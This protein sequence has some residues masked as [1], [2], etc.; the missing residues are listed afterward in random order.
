MPDHIDT[1]ERV[2]RDVQKLVIALTQLAPQFLDGWIRWTEVAR[3]LNGTEEFTVQWSG[4]ASYP[5]WKRL[6]AVHPANLP[7]RVK[8]TD[9]GRD[10]ASQIQLSAPS[11]I[12]RICDSILS[13]AR[14]LDPIRLTVHQVS[15]V[16]TTG[17]RV[18]QAVH[19]DLSDEP[20]PTD[21]P[22]RLLSITATPVDGKIVG[23]E[24]DGSVLYVAFES[25]VLP[26][27]LPATLQVD[28]RFLL[29]QLST[30][31]ET[32]VTIPERMRPL[33]DGAV[34][35]IPLSRRDSREVA[36]ALASMPDP[37]TRLLWGPP[38]AGKTFALAHLAAS[39]LRVDPQH[40]ILLVAPSNRAVDVAVEQVAERLE[41]NG[42]GQLVR[43]RRVLRY[44]YPRKPQTIAHFE[45]LGSKE[46]ESVSQEVGRLAKAIENAEREG[47]DSV[48]VALLRAQFLEKQEEATSKA[49]LH[50]T[51][52]AVV[53]TTATLAYLR[54][55]PVSSRL[56]DT[57]IVDEI[58]MVTPAMCTFLAARAKH[59]LLLAG[60]P[61]QLGP[62]YESA[63]GETADEIEWMGTDLFDKSG[64]SSGTGEHR[65]IDPDDTRMARITSQRRCAAGIWKRVQHLYPE[66]S[67]ATNPKSLQHLIDLLPSPGEPTVCLDTSSV[68][69]K[70]ER[71]K[72][73][74]Q[75]PRSAEVALDVAMTI[76]AESDRKEITVAIITPYRAQVRLLRQLLREERKAVTTPYS[77]S[78][79]EAG[80]VHQFQGSD[81]DVVVFDVVDG[82]GR[83]RVGA[84]LRGDG[85][86]RLVNVAITRAKGKLIVIADK[87]WCRNS[88]VR[89]DNPLLGELVLGDRPVATV[90][91]RQ[92]T[93]HNTP[94]ALDLRQEREK[95][96]SEI[97]RVLF[98][99]IVRDRRLAH[100]RA[101]HHIK[102]RAEAFISRA[103][104]AFPEI[105]YAIYCDSREWHCREDRWELDL[106]QRNKLTA[107]GWIFSVFSG[108][109]IHR[110][111]HACVTQI[112]ET[113]LS[114]IG[115]DSPPR[116]VWRK[117]EE[118]DVIQET[119]IAPISVECD[120]AEVAPTHAARRADFTN[121][122]G[123]RFA[124]IPAGVFLMGSPP[125]ESERETNEGQHKCRLSRGC[126]MSVYPITQ[127][128][129]TMIMGLKPSQF[130]G[131]D[132]RPV[133]RVS[134]HE[135][136]EFCQKLAALDGKPYRL[137]TEAEWECA[138]RAETTTPFNF[139]ETISTNQANFDGN[140][141]YGTG[142]QGVG[143][144][145][146]TPVVEFLPNLWGFHD[147]HGNVWEWCSHWY[148]T[149]PTE[150]SPDYQ[151]PMSGEKRVIR[152]GAWNQIP[153]RCRSAFR[154]REDPGIRR[155]DI[156]FRI[157]FSEG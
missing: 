85:G 131:D 150:E 35:G 34:R 117:G 101:Q 107:A 86:I 11:D 52:A 45:L 64:I 68:D 1:D 4:L 152:G 59:R 136:N 32:L 12:Q 138:C 133:E 87:E 9:E 25:E 48:D 55:S 61:R 3:H 80:T 18:V 56:F 111:S 92:R 77:V 46:H 119:G 134:W 57:V 26:E 116:P 96:E 81:A 65:V 140:Y 47:R 2:G 29:N 113:Y 72:K 14:R 142:N 50:V 97:E 63:S 5:R 28:K 13:Y 67:D 148:G 110:E 38:G 37:W 105:R 74:W 99:A 88:N 20:V 109:D 51:Q 8:L 78:A 62:V 90:A 27:S 129:W 39:L 145:R 151:G 120:P 154:G 24:V 132:T 157:C 31:I 100:V 66:I 30:Q 58:T 79:I 108:R 7:V 112:A 84:L 19:V 147:F 49:A 106:R 89:L 122:R 53:A 71:F 93:S 153:R 75:N 125:K 149:Y 98:D 123:I 54:S 146:T 139:G 155:S 143:R 17:S 40:S 118:T 33:L 82:R 126:Y 6:F 23:Q 104:F 44:G 156:G 144:R 137:P 130:P 42:L 121:S 135:C 95:T 115:V 36:V 91:V 76:V 16:R 127:A 124:W 15:T 21:T 128:Q 114:K 103:D 10:F 69:A 102:D 141:V 41:A 70:C 94:S 73:S 83:D 60:D 22:V 43:D